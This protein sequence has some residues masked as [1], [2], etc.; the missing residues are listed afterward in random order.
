MLSNQ[1]LHSS[2]GSHTGG[3]KVGGP[4]P[5]SLWILQNVQRSWEGPLPGKSSLRH[6]AKSSSAA[7]L[8]RRGTSKQRHEGGLRPCRGTTPPAGDSSF[9]RDVLWEQV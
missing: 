3:N 2:E 8:C 4:T 6:S 5:E 7:S 9:L 1:D